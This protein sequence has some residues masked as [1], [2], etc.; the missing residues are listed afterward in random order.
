MKILIDRT[1]CELCESHCDQHSARLIHA[2][3][4]VDRPGIQAIEEDGRPELTL[5]VKDGVH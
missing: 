4:G 2:P 3:E 5:V 1:H